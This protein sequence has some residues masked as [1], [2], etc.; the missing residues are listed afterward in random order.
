MS[1][2]LVHFRLDNLRLGFHAGDLL[3]HLLLGLLQHVLCFLQLVREEHLANQER[4][5]L[6]LVEQLNL[7]QRLLQAL[8]LIALRFQLRF[9]VIHAGVVLRKAVDPLLILEGDVHVIVL[10]MRFKIYIK[11]FN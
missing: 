6:V 2:Q 10:Q 3:E 8:Q 5:V 11:N 1:L 7:L 9:E 4:Y